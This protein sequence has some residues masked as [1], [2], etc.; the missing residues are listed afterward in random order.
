[1]M[2]SRSVAMTLTLSRDSVELPRSRKS[3]TSLSDTSA[4]IHTETLTG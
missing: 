3:S 4:I 1:M 2:D